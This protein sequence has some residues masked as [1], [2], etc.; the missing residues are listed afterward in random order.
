[1]GRLAIVLGVS[2]SFRFSREVGFFAV[3][4]WRAARESSA[5]M[6]FWALESKAAIEV[7]GFLEREKRKSDDRSPAMKAVRMTLSSFS[8]T[9]K[10]SVL[11]RV[12]KLRR[13]SPSV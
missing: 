5:F 3:G 7:G 12:T 8:A 4:S 11:K 6:Y 1:M 10:A 9:C 13:D 2:E